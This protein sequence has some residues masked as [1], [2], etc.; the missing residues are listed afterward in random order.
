MAPAARSSPETS[1]SRSGHTVETRPTSPRIVAATAASRPDGAR[2][3]TGAV[4]SSIALA[5]P[6]ESG[7]STFIGRHPGQNSAELDQPFTHPHTTAVDRELPDRVLVRAGPLLDHRGST[8][9]LP[10]GL[11]E[12][13]QQ[14]GVAEVSQVQG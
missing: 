1:T 3:R 7:I 6:H 10:T 2:I 8:S 12:A 11:E 13:Q 14:N 5:S 4:C 9:D